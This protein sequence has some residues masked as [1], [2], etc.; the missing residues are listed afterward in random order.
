MNDILYVHL[1]HVGNVVST[2]LTTQ[3]SCAGSGNFPKTTGEFITMVYVVHMEMG[4]VPDTASYIQ[5]M[6]REREA[7]DR[8]E[9]KDNRSFLAKYVSFGDWLWLTKRGTV[10]F[11]FS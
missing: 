10:F 8:G 9:T 5:K 4:P 3:T 7:K 11:L 1:D 2:S 6:E